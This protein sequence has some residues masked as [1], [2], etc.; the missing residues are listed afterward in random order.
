MEGGCLEK[1]PTQGQFPCRSLELGE[2]SPTLPAHP[3]EEQSGRN[4]WRLLKAA[5]ICYPSSALS[6]S[7]CLSEEQCWVISPF[8][9]QADGTGALTV[10]LLLFESW[11]IYS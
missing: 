10:L 2:V 7:L 1:Q 8:G 3:A 9:G 4:S 11:N 5:V 6:L